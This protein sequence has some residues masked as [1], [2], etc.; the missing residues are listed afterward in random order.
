VWKKMKG[1]MLYAVHKCKKEIENK[2]L[3]AH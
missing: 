1:R 2:A 3:E